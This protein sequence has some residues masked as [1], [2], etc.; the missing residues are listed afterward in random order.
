MNDSFYI[1]GVNILTEDT[2]EV[3]ITIR[4]SWC[5]ETSENQRFIRVAH[6][7]DREEVED[8]WSR[9]MKELAM[10]KRPLSVA[11]KRAVIKWNDFYDDGPLYQMTSEGGRM[12]KTTNFLYDNPDSDDLGHEPGFIGPDSYDDWAPPLDILYCSECG[13]EWQYPDK[14]DK[15]EDGEKWLCPDCGIEC[16]EP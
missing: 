14:P 9:A 6:I 5:D 2:E 8:I 15:S 4:V 13:R 16:S 7:T 3:Q 10:G 12:E 1:H 11:F